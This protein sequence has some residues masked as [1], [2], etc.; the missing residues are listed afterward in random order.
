MLQVLLGV[1]HVGDVS[2]MPGVDD[3]PLSSVCVG[4]GVVGLL[5]SLMLAQQGRDVGRRL[6]L[7]QAGKVAHLANQHGDD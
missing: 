3:V 6:Q 7:R 2:S 4:G 1:M 5:S